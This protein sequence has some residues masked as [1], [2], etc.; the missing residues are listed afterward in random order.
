MYHDEMY[1]VN[2]ADWLCDWSVFGQVKALTQ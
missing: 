2:A 1:L